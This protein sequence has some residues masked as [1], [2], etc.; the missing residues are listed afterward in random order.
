MYQAYQI[1]Q[2]NRGIYLVQSFQF[3]LET[4]KTEGIFNAGVIVIK[5]YR[6][7]S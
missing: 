6:E 7:P 5:R 4:K 3:P 1:R 2:G